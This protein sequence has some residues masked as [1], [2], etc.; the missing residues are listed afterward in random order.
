MLV[1]NEIPEIKKVT[2]MQTKKKVVL[3]ASISGKRIDDMQLTIGCWK[4]LLL[5][6]KI[7]LQFE[8][9]TFLK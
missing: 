6:Y 5:L 7:K 1:G 2:K 4:Y 3:K 9:S 8:G